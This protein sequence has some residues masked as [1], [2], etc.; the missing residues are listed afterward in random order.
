MRCCS[1]LWSGYEGS[2][3]GRL[4]HR[5]VCRLAVP[6][7]QR[8]QRSRGQCDRAAAGPGRL[9]QELWRGES[10]GREGGDSDDQLP[11]RLRHQGIHRHG[12]VAG[13]AGW[14]PQ[15]G[16]LDIKVLPRAAAQ[17]ARDNSSQPA[18]PYLRPAGLRRLR[19]R[20]PDGSGSRLG[21]PETAH[22]SRFS[23]F[24]AWRAL[25]V[26]QLRVLDARLDRA[27]A[28]GEAIRRLPRRAN[29]PAAGH[30]AHGGVRGGDLYG[31]RA[32]LRLLTT[33]GERWLD[34]DRPE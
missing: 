14:R 22:H 19:S 1:R 33:R 32:G 27:K 28:V 4:E 20:H 16:R 8:Q 10:R 31:F 23:P 9:P 25:A 26:L 5:G 2:S 15:S 11:A 21:C 7:L 24:P 18:H 3:A 17:A 6:R 29:L 13:R 30:D 34:P 12:D